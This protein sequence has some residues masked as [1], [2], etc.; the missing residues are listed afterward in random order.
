MKVTR[1]GQ[2]TIPQALREKYGIG[3]DS[4]VDFVDEGNKIVLKKRGSR[5]RLLSRIRSARGSATIRMTTDE[6]LKLTRK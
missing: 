2:V 5:D 3:S 1:K 4:E 6:I